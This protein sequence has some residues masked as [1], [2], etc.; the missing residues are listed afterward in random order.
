MTAELDAFLL[1]YLVI[2]ER[3]EEATRQ[4][5]REVAL[6]FERKTAHKIAHLVERSLDGTGRLWLSRL[7]IG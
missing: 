1:L 3:D 4:A 7:A 2:T 6:S 5:L